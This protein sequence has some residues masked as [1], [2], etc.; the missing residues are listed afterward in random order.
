MGANH[1]LLIG[2]NEAESNTPLK[3]DRKILTNLRH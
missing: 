3:A 2:A 1:H